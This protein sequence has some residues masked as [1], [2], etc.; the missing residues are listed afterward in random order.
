MKNK[1]KWLKRPAHFALTLLVIAILGIGTTIAFF[2]DIEA[3]V[4][5]ITFGKIT[6]ETHEH[7]E[8]LTKTDIKVTATGSSECYVRIRVDVPT[9]TYEYEDNGEKKIG[10]AQVTASGLMPRSAQEWEEYA[11]AISTQV[12]R[13]DGTGSRLREWIKKEDGF[14]YLSDILQKG[15]VVTFIDE[16]TYPGLWD[17]TKVVDPLPDG[18]TLDMLTIPIISEAIQVEGI[19]VGGAEGAD[20]AYRAFQIVNGQQEQ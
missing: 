14:W 5:S 13:V 6:I 8:G 12:Y 7:V 11:G 1:I 3:A 9:V 10:T 18:L 16:I 17:G 2:T 15:D 4:N 20:A 19:D